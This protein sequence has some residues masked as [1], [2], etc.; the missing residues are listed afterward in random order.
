MGKNAKG[1]KKH[2]RGK[3]ISYDDKIEVPEE[4]QYFAKITKLLGNCRMG[5]E[6]YYKRDY[7]SENEAKTSEWTRIN[8]IGVIRGNMVKKVYINVGDIVLVTTRDF[9]DKKVDII[10]KYNQGHLDY[11][12]K[13]MEIPNIDNINEQD[14]EFDNIEMEEEIIDEM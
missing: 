6:Y 13:H 2:K 9:E 4:G 1:G 7:T 5:L 14:I 10:F 11:L 8:S 3:N 12:K